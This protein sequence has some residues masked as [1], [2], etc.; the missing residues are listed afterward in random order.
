MVSQKLI[1]YHRIVYADGH[2]WMQPDIEV[3]RRRLYKKEGIK[4]DKYNKIVN[5]DEIVY[6]FS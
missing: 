3:S 6:T 5:F 1:P 2:V 4:L